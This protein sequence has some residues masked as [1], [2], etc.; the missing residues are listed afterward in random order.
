MSFHVIL[1]RLVKIMKGNLLVLAFAAILVNSAYAGFVTSYNASTHLLSV[2]CINPSSRNLSYGESVNALSCTFLLSNVIENNSVGSS[3]LVNSSFSSPQLSHHSVSCVNGGGSYSY[4]NV[5]VSCPAAISY[6]L[7]L[8]PSNHSVS[9]TLTIASNV[10]LSYKLNA[11]K[12]CSIDKSITPSWNS[13]FL[14]AND[15]GDCSVSLNVS[16]IPLLNKTFK[17]NSG[18]NISNSTYGIKLVG[19]HTILNVNKTL[20]LGQSWVY[21]PDNISIHAPTNIT[22][23]QIITWYNENV[24]NDCLNTTTTSSVNGTPI[25][26]Y[27]SVLKGN[28]APDMIDTCTSPQLRNYTGFSQCFNAALL[29]DNMS[30]IQWKKVALAA[31]SNE[32]IQHSNA[33]ENA[34]LYNSAGQSSTDSLITAVIVIV[35]FVGM[36]A[37]FNITARR[38]KDTARPMRR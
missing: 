17:V 34:T 13:S 27:C 37:Y 24:A 2:S 8:T 11:S 15:S 33:V 18:Q 5:S 9:N 31:Q 12:T 21:A 20:G 4:N 14:V 6:N 3:I 16:R 29:L 22:E 1:K 10:V 38:E 30:A 25:F 26:S 19:L 23:A 36:G 7:N 28:K 32:S 35:I